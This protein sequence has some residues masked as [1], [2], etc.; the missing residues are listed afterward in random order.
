[1]IYVVKEKKKEKTGST[2]RNGSLAALWFKLNKP[3]CK[4]AFLHATV[5]YHVPLF[6]FLGPSHYL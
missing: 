6:F 1:M 3:V 4:T 2:G 5:L